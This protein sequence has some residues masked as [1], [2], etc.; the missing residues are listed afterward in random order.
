M[1]FLSFNDGRSIPP[2]FVAHSVVSESPLLHPHAH[3]HAHANT[4]FRPHPFSPEKK[5][6]SGPDASPR[7]RRRLFRRTAFFSFRASSPKRDHPW[8]VAKAAGAGAAGD[9]AAQRDAQPDDEPDPPQELAVVVPRPLLLLRQRPIAAAA[10]R[11]PE[12]EPAYPARRRF[13]ERLGLEPR[14]AAARGNALRGVR[15]KVNGGVLRSPGVVVVAGF[16][17]T[18]ERKD[19]D[20]EEKEGGTERIVVLVVAA[21]LRLERLELLDAVEI[22]IAGVRG[23]L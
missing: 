10:V 1:S 22:G 18:V 17:G 16:G 20:A 15:G 7:R 2:S 3:A 21:L 13:R 19:E 14:S 11:S 4:L 23:D 9:E 6:F 5:A 8:L 12:E